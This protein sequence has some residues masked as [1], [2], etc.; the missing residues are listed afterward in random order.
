VGLRR[1]SGEW[2]ERIVPWQLCHCRQELASRTFSAMTTILMLVLVTALVIWAVVGT[3]RLLAQD[4]YG[5]PEI[6]A[7]VRHAGGP[8]TAKA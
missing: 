3:F 1:S 4:G 7:R 2:Q 8:P 5:L 6:A